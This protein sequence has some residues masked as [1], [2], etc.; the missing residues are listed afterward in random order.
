GR[1]S[2]PSYSAPESAVRALARVVAYSAWAGRPAG[3]LVHFEDT[4][5][6]DARELVRHVLRESPTR[7]E[8]DT[9]QVHELLAGYGIEMWGST[10]VRTLDEA[11]RESERQGWDVVLKA[12]ADHL[13]SRPD[14]AHV[15]RN[16][17]SAEEMRDAW[18]SLT[19]IIDPEGAG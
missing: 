8:L 17:D 14:L 3:H 15:W 4:R 16:I 9:G 10:P 19:A 12:T 18:T 5:Q 11:V 13:R 7:A 2:V 6:A 1:G